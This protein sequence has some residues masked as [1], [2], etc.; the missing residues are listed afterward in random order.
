MHNIE[1]AVY[2]TVTFKEFE[3]AAQT[4]CKYISGLAY[5]YQLKDMLAEEHKKN[6]QPDLLTAALIM[7]KVNQTDKQLYDVL[8]AMHLEQAKE[9]LAKETEAKLAEGKFETEW[10]PAAACTNAPTEENL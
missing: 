2:G 9:K 4:V 1:N 3:Q 8:K 5:T 7:L 10:N 6:L